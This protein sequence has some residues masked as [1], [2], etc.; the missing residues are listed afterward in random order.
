MEMAENASSYAAQVIDIAI[1]TN[2]EENKFFVLDRTN[3]SNI[4][5]QFD[6]IVNITTTCPNVTESRFFT[7]SLQYLDPFKSNRA[8]TFRKVYKSKCPTHKKSF[9]GT[10]LMFIV[11]V[12]EI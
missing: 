7:L 3:R 8:D 6:R 11:F 10:H 9:I 1:I 4:R 5:K 12:I 2:N